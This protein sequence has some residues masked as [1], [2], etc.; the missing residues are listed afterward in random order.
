MHWLSQLSVINQILIIYFLLINLISF[1][2]IG[3]DK[4]KSQLSHW[5]TKETTLWLLALLGGSLGTLLG[6][7][8]FRHKTKK[9]S[10]QIIL[11]LIFF[12]QIIIIYFFLN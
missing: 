9:N 10:F 3:L 2:N 1:F 11:A 6:M 8:F 7:N 4:L 12:L 5:R